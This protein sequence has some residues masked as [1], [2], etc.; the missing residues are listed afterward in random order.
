VRHL[1]LPLALVERL[2]VATA[3]YGARWADVA[4]GTVELT[5]RRE[6]SCWHAG[7][8]LFHDFRDRV[9]SD[10]AASA[11]G[12]I[13]RDRLFF[14]VGIEGA[15]ARDPVAGD[16]S[17]G[18]AP[19]KQDRALGA[20]LKLTWLPSARH[21]L[22]SLTILDGDRSDNGEGARV[23]PEAQPTF[24]TRTLFTSLRWMGL[25]GDAVTAQG[26]VGV[27]SGTVRESPMSCRWDPQHCDD[28]GPIRDLFS[29]TLRQNA[30]RHETQ[31]DRGLD[32]EGRVDAF[33]FRGRR[34]EEHVQLS[35]RVG[36]RAFT[37]DSHVPGNNVL[38][39]V[40]T[41]SGSEP[42][43]RD[44]FTPNHVTSSSLR[45][46][47]ALESTTRLWKRL[48]LIPGLALV[49]SSA[50]NSGG[51]ELSDVLVT[52]H[53]AALWDV[54]GDGRWLVR[55]STHRRVDADLERFARFTIHQPVHKQCDWDPTTMQ[56]S[57]NC[58]LL[59]GVSPPAGDMPMPRTW[60]HTAGVERAVGGYR[61]GLDAVYR[62]TSPLP[63][64]GF[65][66]QG[67]ASSPRLHTRY[68]GVTASA[69]G[70]SGPAQFF[71]AYTLSR[72]DAG[73]DLP[74]DRRHTFDAL[75]SYDLFGHGWVSGIFTWESGRPLDPSRLDHVPG[76][77]EDYPASRVVDP[78]PGVGGNFDP[79]SRGRAAKRFNLQG[80]L[81][82]KRLLKVDVELW[83]D[84][85]NVFDWGWVGVD[86]PFT[87]T[88]GFRIQE[89]R[90]VRLG[91]EYRY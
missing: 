4:G 16:I 8:E 3:G 46:V 38:L 67:L 5:T 32:L 82:G 44:E 65:L 29:E 37:S 55:A 85:I 51:V 52:P 69:A 89:G 63:F 25:F 60:E 61:L 21:R 87:F 30:L 18:V 86:D 11:S 31:Q 83:A 79:S 36:M 9:V 12:P 2:D 33:L 7:G 34:V 75:A 47:H 49:T 22:D 80:R 13:V 35:S 72:H 73:R 42:I 10:A 14:L 91:L 28:V 23:E 17:F 71:L 58:R 62:R 50:R 53:A 74:D 70:R 20:G 56:F 68:R 48:S 41:P 26:A 19:Q 1:A 15:M 43:A 64:T 78:P 59:G 77:F 39:V 81:R 54:L 24:S 27:T 6:S 66:M 90:S 76:L 84:V 57:R 40:G 45:T 88:T